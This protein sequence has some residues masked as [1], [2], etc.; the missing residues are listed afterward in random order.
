MNL[1]AE[2]NSATYALKY[3]YLP[4]SELFSKNSI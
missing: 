3:S 1:V 2:V 4:T